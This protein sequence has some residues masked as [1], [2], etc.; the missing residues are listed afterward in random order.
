[1]SLVDNRTGE[2]WRSFMQQRSEIVNCLSPDLFSMQVYDPPFDPETFR[3][4]NPF[5]KWATC[6][7]NNFSEVPEGM[8]TFELQGGLYAVFLYKGDMRG[9]AEAFRHI[10][11]TWLRASGYIVDHRPHFEL[12]GEKYKNGD[13]QSE[14]EIW[15]PIRPK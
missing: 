5:E 12:L 10:F 9:A 7:V 11:E 4:D 8:R 13:P 3:P 1:M 14:E 2:L 6:E 15:I